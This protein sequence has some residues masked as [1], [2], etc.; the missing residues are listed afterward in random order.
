M[1]PKYVITYFQTTGRSEPARLMMTL[2]GVEWENVFLQRGEEWEAVKP[3]TA[4][5]PLHHVPTLAFDGK[6]ICQS[7]A[8]YR[9]LANE[10]NFYGSSNYERAL[11]DQI[12]ETIDEIFMDVAPTIFMS[13]DSAEKKKEIYTTVFHG[14]KGKARFDFFRSILKQSGKGFFVGNGFTLADV[15]FFCISEMVEAHFP[16]MLNGYE[17]LKK[18]NENFVANEKVKAHIAARQY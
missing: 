5:F 10:H 4:R 7:A 6:I 9:Y 14:P 18:L 3:D 13:Q 17:D 2:A 15:R 11:V 8:I 1:A 12:C 16:E